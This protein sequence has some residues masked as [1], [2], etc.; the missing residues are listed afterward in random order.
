MRGSLTDIEQPVTEELRAYTQRAV[1]LG[2][3]DAAYRELL[4]VG[5]Q[6]HDIDAA[7]SNVVL[8]PPQRGRWF[9]TFVGLTLL[10][11]VSATWGGAMFAFGSTPDIV[12]SQYSV[13]G[14]EVVV[15]F[16]HD[17]AEHAAKSRFSISSQ[18][19]GELIWLPNE[20]ELHFVP[21]AGFEP[22][23]SYTVELGMDWRS[24]LPPFSQRTTFTFTTTQAER[25]VG[26]MLPISGGTEDSGVPVRSIDAD[27]QAMVLTLLE[28]GQAVK[29]FPI[30]AIGNP[31]SGPT[32]QG[33]FDI[34][35]KERNH[36]SSI[37]HVWMPY[38]MQFQGDYFLHGW[39]YWPDGSRYESK[40]SG[41]CIRL[42]EDIAKEVFEWASI[43][44]SL[45]IHDESDGAIVFSSS[46]LENGD[47]VREK[48]EQQAFIVRIVRDERFKRAYFGEV[49]K[50]IP[51][52]AGA[53]DEFGESRWIQAETGPGN[54]VYEL[55]HLG[56]YHELECGKTPYSADVS[57][58][59]CFSVWE[60]YGGDRNEIFVVDDQEWAVMTAAES[61]T[62]EVR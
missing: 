27:L 53:L 5:W 38:S 35:T 47:I 13:V 14:D 8:T 58:G 33:G 28:D 39:P 15:T 44:V 55:D 17:I 46:V 50:V 42:E 51:L 6:Q 20:R 22:D 10:A 25:I 26:E 7:F 30:G 48:G 41:G 18:P 61:R 31:Y 45:F 23:Q 57:S 37:T 56:R 4:A 40:Y 54:P 32:P 52:S 19:E 12:Y 49:E 59:E 1:E 43:G 2:E 34:K 3:V 24:L 62:M 36:F 16:D 11:G 60:L 9:S 29:Q 21:Y